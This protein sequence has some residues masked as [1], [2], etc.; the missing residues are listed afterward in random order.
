MAKTARNSAILPLTLMRSLSKIECR[1]HNLA[2]HRVYSKRIH[3]LIYTKLVPVPGYKQQVGCRSGDLSK[4]PYL[5]TRDCRN[6]SSLT[7]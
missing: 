3:P 2:D 4:S 1:K 7:I 6:V 5:F